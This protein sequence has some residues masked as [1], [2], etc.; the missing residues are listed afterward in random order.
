[1][2]NKAIL[3]LPKINCKNNQLIPKSSK[4]FGKVCIKNKTPTHWE[5]VLLF[6]GDGKINTLK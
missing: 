4:A 6:Y 3:I 2:L 1:M 5:L